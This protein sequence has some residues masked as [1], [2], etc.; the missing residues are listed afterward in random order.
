MNEKINPT[1]ELTIE[2]EV[3]ALSNFG[4]PIT[5]ERTCRLIEK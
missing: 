5:N 4:N 2:T 3:I 1:K